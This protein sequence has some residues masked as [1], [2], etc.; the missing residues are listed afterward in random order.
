MHRHRRARP[1]DRP[2]GVQER[3]PLDPVQGSHVRCG[4]QLGPRA[5]RHRLHAGRFRHQQDVGAPQEQGR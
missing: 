3:H 2:R 1:A 4:R 5:L